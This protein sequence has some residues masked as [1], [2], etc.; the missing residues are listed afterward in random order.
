MEFAY[1]RR[2]PGKGG[3]ATRYDDGEQVAE[4][5]AGRTHVTDLAGDALRRRH[6]A[7]IA[8]RRSRSDRRSRTAMAS[9]TAR[10]APAMTYVVVVARFIRAG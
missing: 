6:D 7:A 1:R 10:G 5:H 9:R 2:R 3:T 4:I 8:R